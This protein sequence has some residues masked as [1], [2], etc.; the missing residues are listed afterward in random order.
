MHMLLKDARVQGAASDSSL[1]DRCYT[2]DW[3]NRR[4][5]S[6]GCKRLIGESYKSGNPPIRS[7]RQKPHRIGP[8]G[9]MKEKGTN[10]KEA[11][12]FPAIKAFKH[13]SAATIQQ[14]C[15]E[16]AHLAGIEKR[17]TAHSLRHSFATHLNLNP[18]RTR[19]HSVSLD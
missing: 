15:R 8:D 3:L 4:N 2:F 18:N 17:V 13:I 19:A 10:N 9:L 1:L 16:S 12:L 5:G 6:F 11:W 7:T 14:V